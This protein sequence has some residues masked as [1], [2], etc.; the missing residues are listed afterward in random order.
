M[1]PVMVL[2][3]D[4]RQFCQALWIGL[5]LRPCRLADRC[6][7]PIRALA[8][9][10]PPDW[11]AFGR[12]RECARRGVHTLS[13]LY[14]RLDRFAVLTK[15]SSWSSHGGWLGAGTFES[16]T[17]WNIDGAQNIG[18][19]L[20]VWLMAAQIRI[21]DVPGDFHLRLVQIALGLVSIAILSFATY[22]LA[23]ARPA[24]I[25]AWVLSARAK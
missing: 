18:G 21:A 2:I 20:H 3:A 9:F 13:R 22:D 11:Y 17:T 12:G 25:V 1:T 7:Y 16:V 8:S 15:D 14:L 19:G 10:G 4:D 24:R 23:G 6:A 5:Y